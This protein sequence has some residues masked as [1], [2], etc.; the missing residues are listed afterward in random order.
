MKEYKEHNK[1]FVS[2]CI[3]LDTDVEVGVKID[4]AILNHIDLAINV[5]DSESYLKR[6]NQ[7]L[8]EGRVV[9]AIF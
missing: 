6:K 1:Y 2:K 5:Y 4:N 8:S 9:D 3:H 7:S